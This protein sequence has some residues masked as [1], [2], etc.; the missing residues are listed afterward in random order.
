MIFNRRLIL[1]SNT[2][3]QTLEHGYKRIR[4]AVA[5]SSKDSGIRAYIGFSTKLKRFI[6]IFSNKII[7]LNYRIVER[8]PVF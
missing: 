6:D 5:D 1:V 2:R 3:R 7:L 4:R 8:I